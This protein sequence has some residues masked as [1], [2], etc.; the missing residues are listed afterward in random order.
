[1]RG[2]YTHLLNW[3]ST[4]VQDKALYLTS[5]HCLLCICI[6]GQAL[7]F[8]ALNNHIFNRQLYQVRG[9]NNNNRNLEAKKVLNI[10][11]VQLYFKY[12]VIL[13]M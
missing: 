10:V 6:Q 12:W 1:M 11:K 7:A 3:E 4:E 8:I 5:L 9:I 13:D 2:Y